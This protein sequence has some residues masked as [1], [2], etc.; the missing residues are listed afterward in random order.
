M[1]HEPEPWQTDAP[2]PA[3]IIEKP[4]GTF[5]ISALGSEQFRVEAPGHDS[6]VGG[7]AEARLLD[8]PGP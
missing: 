8:T 6:Q 4:R 5:S 2:R 1:P 3:V 7:Y